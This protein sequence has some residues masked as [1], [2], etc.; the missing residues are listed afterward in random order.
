MRVSF[1]DDAGNAESLTS[2]ATA[3]VQAEPAAP[4]PPAKPTNLKATLNADGSITLSWTAPEGDVT[5]YQVLR[6]RPTQG[7][8]ILIV[9]VDH[10][11]STA[12]T[13]TD[14]S[15]TGD[16]HY[17]YRVKARNSAGVGPRSNFVRIDR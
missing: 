12:T 11:G 6:R 16:G 10:T 3:A 5:G 8:T 13:Y 9:Y 14:T 17:V 4:D 15:V 7:E 2:A 1:T